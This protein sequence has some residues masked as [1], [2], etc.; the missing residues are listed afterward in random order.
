MGDPTTRFVNPMG[1]TTQ[2]AEADA[3]VSEAT[4]AEMQEL[5]SRY[6]FDPPAVATLL[7]AVREK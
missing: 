5:A 6:V 2:Q 3:A 7:G 1:M 4:R